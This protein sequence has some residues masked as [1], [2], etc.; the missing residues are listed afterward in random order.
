MLLSQTHSRLA[1]TSRSNFFRAPGQTRPNAASF[2]DNQ[3]IVSIAILYVVERN[4]KITSD[5]SRVSFLTEQLLETSFEL[6]PTRLAPPPTVE[7]RTLESPEQTFP[8]RHCSSFGYQCQSQSFC[9]AIEQQSKSTLQ[10]SSLFLQLD[11][12]EL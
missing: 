6:E 11:D 5:I 2:W 12:I 7:T 1:W 9:E 8:R 10:Y 4:V 3:N